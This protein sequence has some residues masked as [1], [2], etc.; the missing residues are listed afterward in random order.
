MGPR[1]A[2]SLARSER[3]LYYKPARAGSKF[4]SR[5]SSRFLAEAA[6]RRH[7]ICVTGHAPSSR[8]LCGVRVAYSENHVW[9]ATFVL[10]RVGF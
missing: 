7:A 2:R 4:L 5:G 6:A 3:G 10:R 8:V 9:L 1:L